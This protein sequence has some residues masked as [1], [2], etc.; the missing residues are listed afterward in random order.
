MQMEG[1]QNQLKEQHAKVQK[2]SKQAQDAAA[3]TTDQQKVRS[4]NTGAHC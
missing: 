1:L 4:S 3:K 2:A